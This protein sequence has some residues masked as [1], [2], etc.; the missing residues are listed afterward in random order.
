VNVL[1]VEDDPDLRMLVQSILVEVGHDVSSYGD[2][3]SAWDALAPGK[4]VPLMIL[5]WM[6]PGMDGLEFCRRVRARTDGTDPVV[7]VITAR[8][9]RD[10]LAKILAAGA[11]DYIAKPFSVDH[12]E[13]RLQIAGR[14]VEVKRERRQAEESR[15]EAARLQGALLAANTVEH[16]L[17]NQLALTMGYAELLAGNPYLPPPADRYAQLALEGVVKATDTLRKLRGIIRLEESEVS[18]PSFIDLERSASKPAEATDARSEPSSAAG[19]RR[20]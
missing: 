12:F 2:A 20:P 17:G 13:V 3:E 10:H 5:D 19:P 11:D 8:Q 1:L 18:G 7:I 4:D 6:L 9:E 15:R 16:H 14:T